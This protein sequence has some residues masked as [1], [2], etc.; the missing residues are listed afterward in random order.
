MSAMSS[1]QPSHQPSLVGK[2]LG[3]LFE[4]SLHGLAGAGKRAPWARR[5]LS[6][7]KITRDL[8]YGPQRPQHLLDVYQPAQGEPQ[9]GGA[10]RP[11]LLYLHGGGFRILS[12][13]TH[14]PM[15]LSFA[16]QGFV[17]FNI[18]Y[19]LSPQAPCPA[20]LEDTALALEWL[21]DNA[22]RFGADPHN[23][24]VAGESAGGNLTTALALAL[25]RP[26]S[27][28][29]ARA[30]FERAQR[31][32]RSLRAAMP[33][34]GFV[35]VAEAAERLKGE[36]SPLILSRVN[37]LAR[38]YVEG[39]E[40]PALAEPLAELEALAKSTEVH[41]QPFERPLPPFLLTVGE[42]D[43]IA[44]QTMRLHEALQGCGVPSE[45]VVY[46]KQGHAFHAALWR[47]QAKACWVDHARFVAPLTGLNL[48]CL[49]LLSLLLSLCASL[50]PLSTLSAAPSPVKNAQAKF[51]VSHDLLAHY[52]LLS[53][54]DYSSVFIG[55][56]NPS[57]Q[58]MKIFLGYE[59]SGVGLTRT[60]PAYESI[61]LLLQ[62][63]R[64]NHQTA[65]LPITFQVDESSM[66]L[67]VYG[68]APEDRFTSLWV[69]GLTKTSPPRAMNQVL[70]LRPKVIS[71]DDFPELMSA[72]S[73]LEVIAMSASALAEFTPAQL[74]ILKASVA[75]GGTLLLDVSEL[76][77]RREGAEL[78]KQ[79][80]S[81]DLGELVQ[82][83]RLTAHFPTPSYRSLYPPHEARVTL[84]LKDIPL[85]VEVPFGLGL[86][87]VSALPLTS[88]RG[89]EAGRLMFAPTPTPRAQLTS[90]LN[91]SS[92]PIS[93]APRLFSRWLWGLMALALLVVVVTQGR[94][95]LLLIG[96]GVWVIIAL[97]YPPLPPTASVSEARTLYI[98]TRANNDFSLVYGVLD[99][100]TSTR[101]PQLIPLRH[102]PISVVNV[103]N[104]SLC[105]IQELKMSSVGIFSFRDPL[106]QSWL[107]LESEV[108][109]RTRLSYM[110]VVD[111]APRDLPD[112]ESLRLPAWPVG[113]WSEQPL[114]PLKPLLSDYPLTLYRAEPSA[115]RLP[116]RP[117][118]LQEPPLRLRERGS[119]P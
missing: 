38:L 102:T 82:D 68:R 1:H 9:E 18:N 84:T 77:P 86:V 11:A 19:H 37:L 96:A 29:Q 34:C 100:S 7:L 87:R 118:L 47:P 107:L 58:E 80:T 35:E 78:L 10:L 33:A 49:T 83:E 95:F 90:W 101:G 15:A 55:Y 111:N 89:A 48:L 67:P 4:G 5:R 69:N 8:A 61:E 108:G 117:P 16:E 21:W 112:A 3:A 75:A 41:T 113:P 88:V 14:W 6:R 109:E 114:T 85:I 45:L 17:V 12:K 46:P 51:V 26:A 64:P 70:S 53:V 76:S 73:A 115:W 79:L 116:P 22:E 65:P 72:V 25:S 44:S 57:P 36:A 40:H 106:K 110:S 20:P 43:V 97:I 92:P 30:L 103:M 54:G 23:V 50:A 105:L 31:E 59:K 32:G 99:V 74:K 60:L 56:R 63:K 66:G 39:S 71:A 119:A 93:M 13:D 81:I 104:T 94:V 98:P 91:A 28:P 24:S 52:K 27:S 62:C 2:A 42:R